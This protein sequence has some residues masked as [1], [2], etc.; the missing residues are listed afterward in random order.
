MLKDLSKKHY[1]VCDPETDGR[2]QDR[3]IKSKYQLHHAKTEWWGKH[4]DMLSRTLNPRIG[5]S[6]D[7]T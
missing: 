7:H 6:D 5:Y 2:V 4:L 1:P 3:M